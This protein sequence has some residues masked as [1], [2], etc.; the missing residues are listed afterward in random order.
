MNN[1][2]WLIIIAFLLL[3]IGASI[4]F[5]SPRQKQSGD[6]NDTSSIFKPIPDKQAELPSEGPFNITDW[7][8]TLPITSTNGSSQPLEIKQPELSAYQLNPWFGQTADKKGIVFRAPV[9]APTTANS[10][11][12]RS[13]LREMKDNGKNEIFWSSSK[14][15]H[16]LFIEEAITATP[17]NKPD[18][19]AGQIHGDDDDLLV[20]RLEG[21]KLYLSRGG[22]HLAVLDE[23][24]V[25]GQRFTFKFEAANG[26]MFTYYNNG[27]EPVYTLEKKVK[28]AYFKIGVYTQSNC[29]TE[30]SSDLCSDDNYGE[31]VIYQAQ[32]THK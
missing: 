7:K 28:Q 3:L 5:F 2:N 18:V 17:K 1:K 26:K 14:G 9:N 13:E 30:E 15:T 4:L 31:V 16:T 12:P 20:I 10:N 29:E 8:L 25:L 19:V 21:S 23:N 6:S 32:V 22:E 24:Y 11:Y 27:A